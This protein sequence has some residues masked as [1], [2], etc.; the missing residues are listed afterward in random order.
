MLVRKFNDTPLLKTLYIFAPTMRKVT[1]LNFH[2]IKTV[3]ILLLFVSYYGSISLFYHSHKIDGVLVSH[4]HPFSGDASQHHHDSFDL[5]VIQQL[6]NF[7]VNI[8][9]GFFFAIAFLYSILKKNIKK[10]EDI[11][12]LFLFPF[13]SNR[14]P[15]SAFSY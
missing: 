10:R 4:S 1:Y 3:F 15:P 8:V 6:S 5:L 11:H 2:K 7:Q 12:F 14:A 9:V 13:G